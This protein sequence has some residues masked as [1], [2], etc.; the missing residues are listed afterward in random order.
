MELYLVNETAKR[1][2]KV[3]SWDQETRIVELQGKLG[4]FKEKFDK[5]LWKRM[6]YQMIKKAA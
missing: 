6:G 3:I 5:E 4:T 2:Y 1:E